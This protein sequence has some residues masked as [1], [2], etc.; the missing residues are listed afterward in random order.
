M[1]RDEVKRIWPEL[2]WIQDDEL[3]RKTTDCWVRAFE[4]SPLQPADLERI[5]FTLLV[6]DCPVTF[7]AHKRL[8]VHVSADAA[9]KTLEFCG[10]ALPIDST[11][12]SPARSSR[13]S[14]SCSSTRRMKGDNSPERYAASTSVTRS[15]ASPWHGVRASGCG[16]PHHRD[17]RRRGQHGGTNRRGVDRAPR[18]LHDLRAV[19]QATAA[20]TEVTTGGHRWSGSRSSGLDRPRYPDR[21][22]DRAR[23]RQHHL[24]LDSRRQTARRSSKRGPHAWPGV[25]DDHA[26]CA[27]VFPGVA[28]TSDDAAVHRCGTGDLGTRPD[29][30]SAAGYSC[31]PRAP[32]R[33]HSNL[34]G[35]GR[36]ETLGTGGMLFGRYRAD[37]HSRHGL[38]ARLRHHRRRHGS[39]RW[40]HGDSAC[41]RRDRA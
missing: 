8:V 31:S 27:A 20:L 25:G 14:A 39:A 28:D 9:R 6:P 32:W 41:H 3:R 18:R 22:G 15:P 33:L 11:R 29:P 35:S 16:H 12:S 5:P 38:F 2:D 4:L 26:D 13:M 17:A 7:M 24:H 37:L 19:R 1:L 23:H 34:E 30:A 21:A 40:R 36:M 10:D